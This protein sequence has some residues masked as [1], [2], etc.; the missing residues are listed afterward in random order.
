MDY[1][2]VLFLS[3]ASIVVLFFLTKLIG[4][5]QI[6]QMTLFDYIVGITIGSIAA[7]MA[8]DIDKDGWTAVIAMAVYALAAVGI[9][10]LSKNSLRLR[11]F[12][13][14]KAL[15]LMSSGV[16]YRDNMKK[17]GLDINELQSQLRLGG[18]FNIDDVD[19][20]FFEPNGRISI[21]PRTQSQPPTAKQL[22]VKTEK[23]DAP[24]NVVIDG[25]ILTHNLTGC[26]RNEEWLSAQLKA[27][28][29][30]DV[31]RVFLATCDSTG[32][33][34]VFSGEGKRPENDP[35]L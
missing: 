23:S 22:G 30:P 5:K 29:H 19:T 15:V 21:L 2:L 11:R 33:L 1:L 18:F 20:V 7:E 25:K 10:V 26:G 34:S 6:S 16:L 35:F 14:G 17:V 3:A 9:S 28:G 8:T 24:K 32:K 13:G 12:F 4:N 27:M 31:E